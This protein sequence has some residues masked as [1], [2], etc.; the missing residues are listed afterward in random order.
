MK[1]HILMS[2]VLMFT[3]LHGAM[4]QTR[5]VSGRVTDQANGG[6]LPGV[7]VLLKGTTNG[8]STNADGGF[9]LSVPESGG[10]LVFSSVG[11][12]TQERTIGSETQFTVSLAT[13]NK[14]L[15][16]VVVT[17]LGIERE[18][19]TLGY[20]VQTLSNADITKASETNAVRSLQGRVAGVQITSASGS[21]GGATRI[22]IRGPQSF[23]G[24][25]QP[26][27]VVDGNVIS[28][29]ATTTQT[30]SGGDLNNGVDLPN[31]GA[32]IDPNNIES[33]T[34]LKGPAAAAL[35][36]AAAASGAIII[37]T[38]KGGGAKGRSQINVISAVT[39]DRVNRL[40]AF[41]NT[42]GSGNDGVYDPQNNQSWGPRMNG[43]NV[44]DWHTYTLAPS[45][46]A[47][48]DSIALVPHPDNVRDFFETGSTYNNSINF[49]GSNELSRFYASVSDVRTNSF[50]PNTNY[51][52]STVALNGSTRLFNKLT[53]G[54]TFNYVNSG[55][56]LGVQG[57]SRGNIIQTIVNTP[58]DIEIK[59]QKDYNDPRYNLTGYYLA[60]FRNNPYFLLANNLLTNEVDRFF[61]NATLS[62]DA[63][64]WLNIT[65]RQS[66]DT[67][68]D[69]R[70]QKIAQG[71]IANLAGRYS[72]D[73]LYGRNLT[74]DFLINVTKQLS[75]DFTLK[76]I[77]GTNYQE[78]KRER[79]TVDAASGLVV[80]GFYDISNAVSLPLTYKQD[81]K[82]RLFGAFA[83]VQLN[84]RNYLSVDV[85]GRNDWSST[86]PVKNRSFFYPSAN[87]SFIFTE[88]FKLPTNILSFGKLRANIASVGKS[89][90]PYVLNPVFV[91]STVDD[92][93]SGQYQAPFQ[94]TVPGFRVGNAL[95]NPDLK[96]ELTTSYEVGTELR[97]FGN[98]INL[99]FTYYNSRSKDIIVAV[100]AASTSGFTS[101]YANAGT[102]ENKGIE[103]LLGGTPISTKSG[104]SWDISVN[105]TRNRNRVIEVN[106]IT[107]N[108]GLGGLSSPSIEARVGQ[109]YNSF[110]GTQMLRDPDGNIVVSATTGQPLVSPVLTTLGSIQPNYLAGLSNT[111]SFKG[112]SLNV[113]FDTKQGGKFWS[114]TINTGYFSGNLKETTANDRQPFLIPNSVVRNTDGTY[115]ANTKLADPYTYWTTIN[116]IGEN[117]LY[118]ASYVKL[119]EASLSYSLPASLVNKVKLTGIQFTLTGRNLFI[120]T[121]ASQ[122][123]LDPEVSAFGTGN[124]QGYEFYSYPSTRSMGASLRLT[125]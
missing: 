80:P 91:K 27:Y 20:A 58:R 38:K 95:G 114:N 76:G 123:H 62:Y 55:G 60:G 99:D 30:N 87:T 104:F 18:R 50:I 72:E 101:Q 2:L 26:I 86:L 69:L 46:A 14:Q 49:S 71:T 107:P 66:A 11:M 59:D 83:D 77:I 37:T 90:D 103:V 52:R 108:I 48:V 10:T 63:T 57:Q 97:F 73:E 29:S 117:S 125:L 105:Y 106:N 3:L 45:G 32:D 53:V 9:S 54:G 111:F 56:D 15:S 98:R 102:M 94:G 1:K 118:D 124:S 75:P 13:D 89:P 42:Y 93:F 16:E 85:T 96:S 81:S 8:V 19:K 88:A 12:V 78:Q 31:R 25:N 121:P 110:Y 74:T 44:A 33:M 23:T 40:P 6:G 7:T 120:W 92:G 70:K 82:T 61:G 84:F 100:P 79:L 22:Q 115:S 68:S 36:G 64:D 109:P 17:A 65:F 4:A 67:Y 21:A 41:Q 122:P 34:I 116:N 35:Y 119:R 5:T 24:N 39:F 112:L 113:L 51:R 47:V 28:N 43:Q